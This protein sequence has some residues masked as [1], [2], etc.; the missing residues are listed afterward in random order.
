MYFIHI[1]YIFEVH[2]VYAH[3]LRILF[4]RILSI[5]IINDF[6]NIYKQDM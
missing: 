5:A 4:V 3:M 2:P 6:I 1:F